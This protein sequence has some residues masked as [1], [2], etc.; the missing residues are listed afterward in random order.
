M[1]HGLN[2]GRF[3][4]YRQV[5]CIYNAYNQRW[6]G[7]EG[8]EAIEAEKHKE[9]IDAFKAKYIYPHMVAQDKKEE[10]N[11]TFLRSLN[12][13]NYKFSTW[14]DNDLGFSKK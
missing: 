5:E 4:C 12:E 13:A 11:A 14:K 10:V 3:Y 8:R 7:Q 9:K 1:Q 2:Q 6:A